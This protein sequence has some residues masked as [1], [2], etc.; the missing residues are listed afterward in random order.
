MWSAVLSE[1]FQ[2][3]CGDDEFGKA[4]RPF[5][6]NVNPQTALAASIDHLRLQGLSRLS[7]IA[8]RVR[9]LVLVTD[10]FTVFLAGKHTGVDLA[11]DLVEQVATGVM[12]NYKAVI[13]KPV[14]GKTLPILVAQ[15]KD[16]IAELWERDQA[17]T[18]VSTVSVAWLGNKLVGERGL[19]LNP[20]YELWKEKHYGPHYAAGEWREIA[21]RVC[22][23]IG[24]LAALRGRPEFGDAVGVI[25]LLGQPDPVRYALPHQFDERMKKFFG[26]YARS[27]GVKTISVA[28][29][30]DSIPMYDAFH[31][32]E[33]SSQR[34]KLT[35]HIGHHMRVLIAEHIASSRRSTGS[36]PTRTKGRPSSR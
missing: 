19:F 6:A 27:L 10:S 11:G 3:G 17:R 13:Y 25:T 5:Y 35:E 28:R 30:A 12:T 14:W 1:E 7:T 2:A 20:A 36:T 29:I 22:T 34:K 21:D 32:R 23:S 26:Y 16:A 33:D 4:V 31:F 15:A 18:L 8:S 9:Y 24:E